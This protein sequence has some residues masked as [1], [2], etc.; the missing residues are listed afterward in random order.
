MIDIVIVSIDVIVVV[1]DNSEHTVVII[2]VG[3]EECID[4]G[5]VEPCP[6]T[7]T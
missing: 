7:P 6:S 5:R 3:Y 1:V 2:V 4:C